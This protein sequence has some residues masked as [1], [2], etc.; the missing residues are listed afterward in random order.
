M[1]SG[2]YSYQAEVHVAMV[3]GGL[4]LLSVHSDHLC[5]RSKAA[6]N[7]C[8]ISHKT[9][10]SAGRLY[11]GGHDLKA[12]KSLDHRYSTALLDCDTLYSTKVYSHS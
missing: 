12:T 2:V 4:Q 7:P 10:S 3:T 1:Y 8:G 9:S 6:Y 5:W 11:G